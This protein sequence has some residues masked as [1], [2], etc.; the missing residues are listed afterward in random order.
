MPT[1]LVKVGTLP[2]QIDDF[3][4][5]C[6]RSCRGSLHIRTGTL[7]VTDGEWKHIQSRHPALAAQMVDVTPPA[8]PPAPPIVPDPAEEPDPDEEQGSEPALAPSEAKPK[9]RTRRGGSFPNA[10]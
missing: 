7:S 6:E 4:D 10:D 5:G 2:Q 3:P 9:R 8:T 1:L